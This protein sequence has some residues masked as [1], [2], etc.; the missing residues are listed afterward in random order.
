MD[1]GPFVFFYR[2]YGT[3]SDWPRPR[4]YHRLRLPSTFLSRATVQALKP[5]L[6]RLRMRILLAYP[7]LSGWKQARG[8]RCCKKV[9][10]GVLGQY[11][12]IVWGVVPRSFLSWRRVD[13][14]AQAC[15]EPHPSR[16]T[17]SSIQ[18]PA[19]GL[20][21]SRF[22]QN[23]SSPFARCHPTHWCY[24]DVLRRPGGRRPFPEVD[25]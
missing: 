10:W 13:F 8:E 11:D 14:G 17:W 1:M 23:T 20:F 7:T 21:K 9:S 15:I 2:P 22:K 5:L 25:G 18:G 12:S 3:P 16:G 24:R 4:N 19:S 6:I